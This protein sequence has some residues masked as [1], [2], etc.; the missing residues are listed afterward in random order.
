MDNN[1]QRDWQEEAYNRNL[2]P[3]CDCSPC[4][5][6]EGKGSCE[7]TE[8]QELLQRAKQMAFGS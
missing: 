1:E 8:F 6:R 2:C 7:D 3:L 4:M 5:G